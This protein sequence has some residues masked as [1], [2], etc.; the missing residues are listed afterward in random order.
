MDISAEHQIPIIAFV[1]RPEEITPPVIQMANRTGSRAIFDVSMIGPDALRSALR[2]VPPDA[3]VRD[4]KISAPALMNPSLVQLLQEKG[5]QNL[6]V[7]CH[8]RFFRGDFSAL[9]KRWRELAEDVHFFPIIGDLD[10]LAAVL[11]DGSGIGHVV[12]KGCE[13]SGFASSETTLV[14]YSAV[15][16]MQDNAS[17]ARDILIWGGVS[18]PEAA[19]ALLVTGA[20][21]IVFESVHWLTDQVA[22]DD[23]QRRRLANLRLDSTDLVG[24]EL[25]VP[26]RLFNKGNSVAF[27]EIR[28]FESSLCGAEIT[29]ESRRSFADR[30][31]A[32]I[33]HPLESHFSTDEL[34]PLGVETAFAA[35][36]AERYG[37][38][39][40]AA[41]QS[42]MGEIRSLCRL[43]E[44]KTDFFL[45][46]PRMQNLNNI[47][48][49]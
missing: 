10:L 42:F 4:I 45:N 34:I 47:F 23:L 46:R 15:K 37:T 36:F 33:I 28:Q 5:V 16:K 27:K 41:V 32:G 21:G 11:T 17:K 48:K 6:W 2:K 30:V 22:V 20:S 40:E 13:A 7:E 19:A 43:A 3:Q 29:E 18:T 26:C 9:L 24:L 8:P 31:N 1:W 25:Q 44:M 39:T 12:L 14:L 35:S 49:K 38:E